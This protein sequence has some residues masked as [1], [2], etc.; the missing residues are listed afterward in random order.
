MKNLH[1]TLTLKPTKA[2]VNKMALSDNKGQGE[3]FNG[4]DYY[5]NREAASSTPIYK[6]GCSSTGPVSNP[7]DTTTPIPVG[8]K[9]S[10]LG[11]ADKI[12]ETD[13]LVIA[14]SDAQ[15]NVYN[16]TLSVDLNQMGITADRDT[17][18][19]LND[20]EDVK[21]DLPAGSNILA[22]D[23]EKWVPYSWPKFTKDRFIVKE[24]ID[25]PDFPCD[26]GEW[27]EVKKIFACDAQ[28]KFVF[29]YTT[30]SD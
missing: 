28:K 27:R 14:R 23:G 25:P 10:Q 19:S 30:S 21:V 12:Q 7:G 9:I 1:L 11:R 18:I 17:G 20:L 29:C 3:F 5:V 15:N 24:G 8:Q 2:R 13:L 26:S 16:Q 6:K 22:F 4:A